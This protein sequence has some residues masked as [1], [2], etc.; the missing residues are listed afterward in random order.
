MNRKGGQAGRGVG[1]GSLENVMSK[2]ETGLLQT[3]A[4]RG[5]ELGSPEQLVSLE[6]LTHKLGFSM[7]VYLKCWHPKL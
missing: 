2:A 4:V 7:K 3:T 5:R 6:E 1:P